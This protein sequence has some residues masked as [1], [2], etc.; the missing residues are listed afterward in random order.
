MTYF[1]LLDAP[2]SQWIQGGTGTGVAALIF[3]RGRSRRPHVNVK[4][5]PHEDV[6]RG[7]L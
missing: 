6:S 7:G 3:R 2:L 5:V 1:H 4:I